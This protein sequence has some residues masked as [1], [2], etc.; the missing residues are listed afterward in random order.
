MSKMLAVYRPNS[1]GEL[2]RIAI[3]ALGEGEVLAIGDIG[4]LHSKLGRE[5]LKRTM[6]P[7]ENVTDVVR[8]RDPTTGI[9]LS[10][11]DLERRFP[12]IFKEK[13]DPERLETE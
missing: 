8:F 6:S 4:I 5:D 13:G 7:G 12:K 3:C 2:S 10:C 11:I 1:N 9:T